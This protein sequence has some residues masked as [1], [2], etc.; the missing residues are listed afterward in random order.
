LYLGTLNR[1]GDE[2]VIT[3]YVYDVQSQRL[4]QV[5]QTLVD[6]DSTLVT[7]VVTNR[8]TAFTYDGVGRIRSK[9]E[10]YK[11]DTGLLSDTNLTTYY[12]Y[13]GFGQ[14]RATSDWLFRTTL[15][16]YDGLGNQVKQVQNCE[17]GWVVFVIGIS[18][19]C[20]P[21]QNAS[22]ANVTTQSV[23]D[24]FSRLVSRT[25]PNNLKTTY[26]Y[27]ALDRITSV[28]DPY[29]NTTST[30]YTQD[31]NDHTDVIQATDTL[32]HQTTYNTDHLGRQVKVTS[33]LAKTLKTQH[34]GMGQVTDQFDTNNIRTH[35]DYDLLGR[36]ITVTENYLGTP[37][38]PNVPTDVDVATNYGYDANGNLL[39]ITPPIGGT[40]QYEYDGVNRRTAAH[41]PAPLGLQTYRYD[42]LGRLADKFTYKNPT[43]DLNNDLFTQIHNTYDG[44][45]RPVQQNNS[46]A[47]GSNL[48]GFNTYIQYSAPGGCNQQQLCVSVGTDYW[49]T[50]YLYDRLDRF[51]GVSGP[52]GP[53]SGY[54]Y[55]AGGRLTEIDYDPHNQF[56]HYDYQAVPNPDDPTKLLQQVV[57]TSQRTQNDPNFK[58]TYLYDAAQQLTQVT[59]PDG[60]AKTYTR[61]ADSHLS[62]MSYLKGSV[63][64]ADFGYEPDGMGNIKTANETYLAPT[65]SALLYS[66]KTDNTANHVIYTSNTDGTG[67][68]PLTP[69]TYDSAMP[70]WSPDGKYI[71]YASFINGNWQLFVANADGS[72]AHQVTLGAHDSTE[73][74]WAPQG[75][76]AAGAYEIL[77]T[78]TQLYGRQGNSHL[79]ALT[80]Q[81]DGTLNANQPVTIGIF[82]DASPSWSPDGKHIAFAS[83]RGNGSTAN[84]QIYVADPDGSN[85]RPITVSLPLSS[86]TQPA[87]GPMQNGNYVLAFVSTASNALDSSTDAPNYTAQ[88]YTVQLDSTTLGVSNLTQITSM[89]GG[90]G[91]INT[92]PTWVMDKGNTLIFRSNR[93]GHSTHHDGGFQLYKI[94]ADGASAPTPLSH[95]DNDPDDP[96]V[97][98]T[99]QLGTFQN[100]ITYSYDKLYRLN[101]ATYTTSTLL[102][103]SQFDY[104]YDPVGN[105]TAMRFTSGK[106]EVRPNLDLTYTYNSA[107]QLSSAT[108]NLRGTS[109]PYTYNPAGN[110]TQA[111]N[112]T[113]GFD[114]ANHLTQWDDGT[115]AM[116]YSYDGLGNRY[117]ESYSDPQTSITT[118][119]L[120]DFSSGQA[121]V[122][123]SVSGPVNNPNQYTLSTYLPG[124]DG[125]MAQDVTTYAGG[126]ATEQGSYF[127]TDTLGSARQ[128]RDSNGS[129]VYGGQYDPYGMP[130]QQASL[131]ANSSLPGFGY[132]GE[133]TDAGSLL[134]LRARYYDPATGM[135]LGRDP[136]E[137]EMGQI[138]SR[139]GY[140]Y[141]GGNPINYTDSSGMCDPEE[142][143]EGCIE[144][145]QWDE[146][147]AISQWESESSFNPALPVAA[148]S[149]N[150]TDLVPQMQLQPQRISPAIDDAWLTQDESFTTSY[151]DG[152]YELHQTADE[153]RYQQALDRLSLFEL[154]MATDY[155]GSALTINNNVDDLA[156][157]G[158]DISSV[159]ALD[160]PIQGRLMYVGG[161]RDFNHL[162][163]QDVGPSKRMLAQQ[164]PYFCGAA[165]A[166]Q[167]LNDASV[168]RNPKGI[169]ITQEMI[170]KMAKYDPDKGG[171]LFDSLPK[172]MS[173]L[174]PRLTYEGGGVY[175]NWFDPLNKLGHPWIAGLQEKGGDFHAV[176]VDKVEGDLVYLRDP[177]QTAS[178]KYGYV[179]LEGT[180]KVEDFVRVWEAGDFSAIWWGQ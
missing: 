117:V 131:S 7:P 176:I 112:T 128:V 58:T 38:D 17:P 41:L 130:L 147:S 142:D 171:T 146:Y 168:I 110:L 164:R 13:N 19:T 9:T 104:T 86:N 103:S 32:G 95:G 64:L 88:I 150:N 12:L 126:N 169:V 114:A 155:A 101:H 159:S 111:G 96:A 28:T 82:D 122:L 27:D 175:A 46:Y 48:P 121:Q 43:P 42:K 97:S 84:W 136:V 70:A 124:L 161:S 180:M 116:Q 73:P 76:Q 47:P 25:D 127:T 158:T 49:G 15:F 68:I 90:L 145:L 125:P 44:I 1:D 156:V 45:D 87:W 55:D 138:T 5:V 16:D 22:D 148:P 134:Y 140:D 92:H 98:T 4:Q 26:G 166:L 105:R 99:A 10:N 62:H 174:N 31:V 89:S 179:G 139:N 172:I 80:L 52:W 91:Q 11:A 50:S 149:Q 137:G 108:D 24:G 85:A 8:I 57:A 35:F 33:P 59:T 40:T 106:P 75:A 177:T 81:A 129:P 143:P 93:D 132:T 115:R 72:N 165:C 6:P 36:M 37:A 20:D 53:G 118:Y 152:V 67:A 154:G 66:A 153:A 94:V 178:A 157:Q 61:D 74:T 51:A 119:N 65:Q 77:Y 54:H 18:P 162:P 163:Y 14:L 3:D 100:Q 160:T 30:V 135:F 109:T 170:A 63:H 39:S 60:V 69:A 78:S 173:K 29:N 2:D 123:S 151:E 102:D 167:I 23:Y 141:V 56:V 83:T 133:E 71:A 21:S 120:F 113:Y 79:Y 34:D 107:N 144:E